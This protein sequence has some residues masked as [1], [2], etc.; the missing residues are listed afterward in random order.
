MIPREGESREG[1]RK[2]LMSLLTDHIPEQSELSVTGELHAILAMPPAVREAVTERLEAIDRFVKNPGSAR[3]DAEAK[4]L[5]IGRRNFYNLVARVKLEGPSRALSPSKAGYRRRTVLDHEV[6]DL[7]ENVIAEI[8]SKDPEALTSVVVAA[9]ERE[10]EFQ[11]IK[12]P[13]AR[14]IGLRLSAL[15]SEPSS[16]LSLGDGVL[17]R[18]IFI[19]QT[20]GTFVLV[21]G[22]TESLGL[23]AVVV[24]AGTRLILSIGVAKSEAPDTGYAFAL[25][26]W[27]TRRSR[28]PFGLFEHS[29]CPERI[30]WI[31]PDQFADQAIHWSR[32]AELNDIAGLATYRGARRHGSRI[33]RTLG[34]KLGWL[35]FL[36]RRTGQGAIPNAMSGKLPRLDRKSAQ[37]AVALL[38][39][40]WN[41][42]LASKK[43]GERSKHGAAREQQIKHWAGKE[44]W[45]LSWVFRSIEVVNTNHESWSAL[46]ES[47]AQ[48]SRSAK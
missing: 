48:R 40:T 44:P 3:A 10:C 24:D 22:E 25:E 8:L 15:R 12:P 17:G 43:A 4:K 47:R 30:H 21:D 33:L 37:E 39:D 2:R 1:T 28:L 23:I 38:A 29:E 41:H 9:V 5:R 31:M 36:P 27:K 19:D 42:K 11:G 45:C 18:E 35:R 16:K 46:S 26:D 13:S 20:A 34:S 32:H 14:T 7:L 6:G